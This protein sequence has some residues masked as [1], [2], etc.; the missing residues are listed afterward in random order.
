MFKD[1]AIGPTEVFNEAGF[2]DFV[3]VW[4][5]FFGVSVVYFRT[6]LFYGYVEG[7]KEFNM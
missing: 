7:V 1:F 6:P 3:N 5:Y 4:G 2:Y